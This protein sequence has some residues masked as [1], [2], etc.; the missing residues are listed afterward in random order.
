MT[1]KKT[2]IIK[3]VVCYDN[4]AFIE[5]LCNTVVTIE[6]EGFETEIQYSMSGEKYS[7]LVIARSDEDKIKTQETKKK[8]K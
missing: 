6:A 8:A 5:Q 7:A 3:Q 1:K 2:N 4:R